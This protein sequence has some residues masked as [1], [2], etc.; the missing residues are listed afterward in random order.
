MMAFAA[1]VVLIVIVGIATMVIV[2]RLSGRP[3]RSRHLAEIQR[4][5]AE[6][7][8]AVREEDESFRDGPG[9]QEDDL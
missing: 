6:E 1:V 2:V 9:Q 8:A 7:V 3:S 4:E 5:A